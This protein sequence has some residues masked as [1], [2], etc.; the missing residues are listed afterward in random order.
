MK[1]LPP[2]IFPN[3]HCSL[4]FVRQC[5][6]RREGLERSSGKT[7]E[8]SAEKKEALCSRDGLIKEREVSLDIL[9]ANIYW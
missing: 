1:D 6:G 9:I 7:G 8:R 4:C 5:A 2:I 3:P